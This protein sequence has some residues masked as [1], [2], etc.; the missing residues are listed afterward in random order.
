MRTLLAAARVARDVAGRPDAGG[1]ARSCVVDDDA[2]I[3]VS[4]PAASASVEARPDA[5]ADHDEVGREL[6]AVVERDVRR[7]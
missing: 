1:A 4:G 7:R 5:D 6:A 2:A 3:D